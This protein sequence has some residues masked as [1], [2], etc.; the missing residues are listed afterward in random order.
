[1]RSPSPVRRAGPGIGPGRIA[2]RNDTRDR[3][4]RPP[5]ATKRRRA[6]A[7]PGPLGRTLAW[8]GIAGA[9][10]ALTFFVLR[11]S[12][13]QPAA[14]ERRDDGPHSGA[15]R[16]GESTH[17]DARREEIDLRVE[18]RA[19]RAAE[20]A[21]RP[22][23][24]LVPG[25]SKSVRFTDLLANGQAVG[26]VDGRVVVFVIGPL[27]GERARVRITQVKPKYAVGEVVAYESQSA[28]R[29][30]PFC[31]R[32]RRV[33]RLPGAAPRISRAARVERADRAQRAAPH[34]RLRPSVDVRRPIG[35]T[36]PRSYRNKMALVVD[37]TAGARPVFGF[38]RARSHALVPIDACPVVLPQ[39]DAAIGGLYAAARAPESRAAFAGA[40]H[41][42]VRAGAASRSGRLVDHDRPAVAGDQRAPH[43][44]SRAA[45]RGSSGSPTPSSRARPTRCSGARCMYRVGPARDGGDDRRRPLS[46]LAGVVL[47]GQQRDGGPHLSLLGAGPCAGAPRRRPVLRR[48]HVRDLLRVARR[49]RRRRSRRT[50]PRC[51]RR[52]R[53]RR[54]TSVDER[55]RFVEGRVEGAVVNADGAQAL[56]AADIVFLDPP[57]KGS[58]D[59]TL[60]AIATAKR[61]Q[62]VVPVVQSGDARA[63]PGV[64]RRRGYALGVVQPFDMFPQTGHVETLATLH[65]AGGAPAVD[66]PEREATAW[67]D[68]HPRLAV[69]GQIREER[70]PRLRRRRVA[71]RP[72][73][74]G[75]WWGGGNPCRPRGRAPRCSILS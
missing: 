14:A 44:R 10:A 47:P 29:A 56:A 37:Q 34:R 8:L 7:A 3:S 43:R 21:P 58:D 31:A 65:H 73:R 49:A 28:M 45:S 5:R 13:V 39:L 71:P 16:R 11:A 53:T 18:P 25:V 50:A 75:A 59:A 1:M 64:P 74:P 40:K 32:V 38:Y 46:R 62:R 6:R 41:V 72:N 2:E 27:P 61:P 68:Q 70:L 23:S 60:D 67:D 54:S 35:M 57:R 36:S 55:A 63:R 30:R 52:A 51:A 69:R 24:G 22:T 12:G 48:R 9:S 19:A 42:I 20:R 33:R 66:L 4:D 15:H 26:R 17:Q